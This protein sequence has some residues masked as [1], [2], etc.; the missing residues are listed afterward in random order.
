[1]FWSYYNNKMPSKRQLYPSSETNCK[2]PKNQNNQKGKQ[3]II[4]YSG[5]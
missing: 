3:I 4:L 1:M 5:F 2:E